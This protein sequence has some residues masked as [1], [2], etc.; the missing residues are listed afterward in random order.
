MLIIMIIIDVSEQFYHYKLSRTFTVVVIYKYHV[1]AIPA[2]VE[3]R[4]RCE[5][6]EHFDEINQSKTDAFEIIANYIKIIKKDKE[7]IIAVLL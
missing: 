3:G 5:E 7:L 1:S 4:C 2:G 6:K